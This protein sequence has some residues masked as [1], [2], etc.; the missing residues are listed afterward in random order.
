M[1]AKATKG[2]AKAKVTKE[3]DGA[4]KVIGTRVVKE[5][6]VKAKG[7]GA[8]QEKDTAEKDGVKEVEQK[9]EKFGS[10]EWQGHE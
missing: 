10:D 9:G 2:K 5:I 4:E 8:K 7:I 1:P 3:K 6:G